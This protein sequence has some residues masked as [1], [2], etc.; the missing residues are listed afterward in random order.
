MDGACSTY[1]EGKGEVCT[2]FWSGNLTERLEDLDIDGRTIIK[3]IFKK[4]DGGHVLD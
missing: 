1:G 3:G 4:M 2:G